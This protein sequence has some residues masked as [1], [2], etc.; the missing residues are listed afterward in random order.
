MKQP[1]FALVDC[2][3]FFVSCERVF[4]PD[5]LQK[6]VAVLSNNDGC[7][8]A[9]SEEVKALGVPMGVPVFKVRDLLKQHKVTLF[10][11][12][13]M[14][15]GDFSQRV[16]Q[17]LRSECPVIEVY[18]VD[19]SF[20]EISNLEITDYTVWAQTLR[21][22]IWQWTGIPVSIGIA[23]TK[24]LA[25]AAAEYAKKHPKQQG[26]YLL[27]SDTILSS[28]EAMQRRKSLLQWLSVGD[29]WG[30]GWRTAP[31]LQQRGISTAYD[32]TG[33]SEGWARQQLS[34]RG[35]ETVKELKGE[36]Q[37]GIET[38]HEPQKSIMVT[39]SFGHTIRDIYELEG[40]VATFAARAAAK[41][42]Q[43][44]EVTQGLLVFLRT[45]RAQQEIRGVSTF[46][47]LVQPSA[48]T[49]M[50]L[51]A[52]LDG[53]HA[54]YDPD[55]SY[56]KAG[57]VLIGLGSEA[58]LQLSF[59]GQSSDK[60]TEQQEL[61]QAVDRINAKYH[62]RLVRHASEHIARTNWQSLHSLRSPAYTA[63]WAQLPII[64]A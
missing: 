21:Q 60:I 42:R 44:Q 36:P 39:R 45:S 26:V 27:A 53:L 6:P 32:L 57:V 55:L 54:I 40:A 18:S 2:N 31:K 38:F 3:N 10:S 14:L 58:H 49:G 35:L 62:T 43:Q 4:R 16:V 48:D 64:K 28:A 20:L 1:I 34:I 29:I 19:E 33:V 50:L 25:K 24:T 13:F 23:P 30:I 7:I 61:M 9:R 11:G 37:K 63:S 56:K 41:L 47:K 22:K 17:T 52:A 51:Q 46:V 59:L 5:L 12:N 8:V 15:Y